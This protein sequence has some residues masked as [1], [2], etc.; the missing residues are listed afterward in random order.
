MPD[1][2]NPL[3]VGAQIHILAPYLDASTCAV[4]AAAMEQARVD[5]ELN[6]NLRIRHFL[7][8]CATETGGFRALEE[9]LFY[10]DPAHLRAVFPHEISTVEDAAE[11]IRSGRA[12]IANRVYG[13]RLGNGP[14]ASGDGWKYRGRGFIQL[15]GRANYHSVGEDIGMDIESSPDLLDEPVVAAEAA[16]KYWVWRGCNIYA[17]KD[18]VTGVRK[19]INPALEGLAEAR[20]WLVK[21]EQI[22]R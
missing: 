3:I 22:W 13:G 7:A 11:L 14:E 10:H 5:G 16:A 2:I 1:Q 6:D 20:T 12:A 15:T 9:N 19:L 8:Q 17:D 4:Y 18:D 21:C